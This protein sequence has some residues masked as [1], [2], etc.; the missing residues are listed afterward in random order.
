MPRKILVMGLPGAGKTTLA[1]ALA[2]LVN[3]VMFNADAVRA[4]LWPDLGFSHK[5]RIEQARRTGWLCDRV[6]EAGGTAIA[7]FICPTEETRAAFGDAFTIWVDRISAG[8][9]DDT[10]RLFTAP[11]RFDLRVNADGAPQY[12]AVQAVMR[13]RPAFTDHEAQQAQIGRSHL[14]CEYAAAETR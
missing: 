2:P 6:V 9:F 7:D 4:N 14:G 12:W 8:R 11:A 5:D 3:A 13:L 1:T 10:N